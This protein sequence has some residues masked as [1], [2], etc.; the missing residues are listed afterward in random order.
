MDGSTSHDNFLKN[1]REIFRARF[2]EIHESQS[3]QGHGELQL[4]DTPRRS[5]STLRDNPANILVPGLC[6]DVRGGP[7]GKPFLGGPFLAQFFELH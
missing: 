2:D 1:A 5:P 4:K 6:L 7:A 3:V